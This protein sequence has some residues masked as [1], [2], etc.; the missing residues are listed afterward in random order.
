MQRVLRS[1][2]E[3]PRTFWLLMG[4]T[5]IDQIGRFLLLPFFALYITDHF[6]ISMTQVGQLFLIW[7]VSGTLGSFA[8]GAIA[9]KF[10]RKAI[11]IFGL[12]FSGA[13]SLF[14]GFADDVRL[15]FGLAAL[16]GFLSDIGSP[17]QAAM[18]TDLL[19]ANRRAEGFSIWRVVANIAAVI[20]PLLAG[21]LVNSSED[22]IRLFI[23]DAVA[24]GVT[25]L[26]VFLAIPETKPAPV[27]GHVPESLLQV[28][29]GYRRVLRDYVYMAFIVVSIGAS[30]VYAQMNTTMPVYMRD[31]SNIA[32][33]G[34]S[35]LLSLNGAMVVLLQF[36][37]TRQLRS[38]SPMLAMAAGVLLYAIGFGMFGFGNTLGYFAIAMVII[39]VGEMVLT[40][41]AQAVAARF[42][43]EDMRGRYLAMFNFSY[44]IPFAIGP[45]LAGIIWDQL[46]PHWLWYAAGIVG[47]ICSVSYLW[48][49]ARV[50][51]RMGKLGEDEQAAEAATAAEVSAG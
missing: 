8:S 49:Q 33:Q 9:D 3:Y 32:P 46:E 36:W 40:P 20:G 5:L 44:A 50:G 30:M 35:Y 47:L 1:Y 28:I 24:S 38:Y 14:I 18:I 23:A 31:V 51:A 4:A 25:A 45:L 26:I 10:G 43:P 16:V 15:V 37:I 2:K 12:V 27:E 11:I 41:V 7:S 34:Y 29:L 22:Y 17:A 6:G 19:P 48:L 13:T 21:F 39:T 42:A